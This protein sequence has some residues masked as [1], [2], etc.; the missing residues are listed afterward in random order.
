MTTF[1]TYPELTLK[2]LSQGILSCKPHHNAEF[3]VAE[4]CSAKGH[5][6]GSSLSARQVSK[7]GFADAHQK[8]RHFQLDRR[9][10]FCV[11][12]GKPSWTSS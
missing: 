1:Y 5:P 11:R 9:A 7:N 10:L 2:K 12:K 3:G 4:H 8:N 6:F